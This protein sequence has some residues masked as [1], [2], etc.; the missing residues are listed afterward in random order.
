MA[1]RLIYVFDGKRP[2]GEPQVEV[3]TTAEFGTALAE[4]WEIV[5][6]MDG[7]PIPWSPAA[8]KPVLGERV[9]L[10]RREDNRALVTGDG[11]R[12]AGGDVVIIRDDY[13]RSRTVSTSEALGESMRQLAISLRQQAQGGACHLGAPGR[14]DIPGVTVISAEIVA[15]AFDVGMQ[16]GIAGASKE[17][18]PFPPG[19]EAHTIWLRGYHKGTTIQEVKPGQSEME[20]AYADGKRTVS[21]FGPNDEVTCPYRGYLRAEWERGYREAGGKIV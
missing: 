17:S 10:R 7:K 19:T 1:D 12:R 20:R 6:Q 15:K 13:G 18:N 2:R 11:E 3:L 21:E 9:I 16:A 8:S 4:G 14:H 5:S